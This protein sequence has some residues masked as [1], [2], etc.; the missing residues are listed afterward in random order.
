[1]YFSHGILDSPVLQPCNLI[2]ELGATSIS[3]SLKINLNQVKMSLFTSF[4]S[5]DFRRRK[6]F[7]DDLCISLAF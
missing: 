7:S 3:Q 1:M 4:V 6:F 2:L 5:I